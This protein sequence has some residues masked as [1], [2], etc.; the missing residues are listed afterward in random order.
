VF[1]L[2]V[3]INGFL[4][5]FDSYPLKSG[6]F[7]SPQNVAKEVGWFDS[8]SVA[9]CG[10][11]LSGTS[12][13]LIPLYTHTIPP[14]WP[15]STGVSLGF[16]SLVHSPKRSVPAWKSL[17]APWSLGYLDYFVTGL[18][19]PNLYEAASLT[20]LHLYLYWSWTPLQRGTSFLRRDDT[21]WS[22]D[23]DLWNNWKVSL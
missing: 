15:L 10:R 22:S 1:T 14:P 11:A 19:A 13:C 16:W 2:R 23:G 7:Q 17:V 9:G 5:P 21:N 18:D 6:P 4:L 3:A 12:A 20:M 8:S